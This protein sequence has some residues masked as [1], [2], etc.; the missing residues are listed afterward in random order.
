[1][2]IID[3]HNDKECLFNERLKKKLTFL[4]NTVYSEIMLKIL[5]NQN[6]YAVFYG[7]KICCRLYDLSIRT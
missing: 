1:M 6:E 2:F 5:F 4:W 3:A 7:D